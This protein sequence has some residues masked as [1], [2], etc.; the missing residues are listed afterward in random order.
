MQAHRAC[1]SL[2][3][4]E[5]RVHTTDNSGDYDTGIDR[6]D[7]FGK[8]PE[9]APTSALLQLLTQELR[10]HRGHVWGQVLPLWKP[11]PWHHHRQGWRTLAIYSM[12]IRRHFPP[13]VTKKSIILCFEGQDLTPLNLCFRYGYIYVIQAL[14]LVRTRCRCKM[15]QRM[16]GYAG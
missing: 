16:I 9:S 8:C 6:I 4:V 3:S 2:N 14:C 7:I 15:S 10:C 5:A 13:P 12:D 11:S 1:V